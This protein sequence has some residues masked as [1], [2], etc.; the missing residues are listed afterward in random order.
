MSLYTAM[1]CQLV[2]RP[3]GTVAPF[4]CTANYTEQN[5]HQ[6]WVSPWTKIFSPAH[7]F[8]LS[9]TFII[10]PTIRLMSVS[11]KTIRHRGTV[12]TPNYTEQNTHQPWVS[13]WT[14]IFSPAHCF[15]FPSRSA[16]QR[17]FVVAA[18]HTDVARD[19][20]RH[21]YTPYIGYSTSSFP[22]HTFFDQA[23]SVCFFSFHHYIICTHNALHCSGPFVTIPNNIS[24]LFWTIVTVH[25]K[26]NIQFIFFFELVP[27]GI[28]RLVRSIK[29]IVIRSIS[30]VQLNT[31]SVWQVQFFRCSCI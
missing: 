23:L 1:W 8:F 6:P 18:T 2:W 17:Q 22:L 31:Q 28:R 15:F 5:T 19:H 26:R 9:V 7:F 4:L 29:T 27:V 12:C 25:T 11:M 13:P 21:S 20:R 3:F 16:F 10:S 30:A 14:R 24:S